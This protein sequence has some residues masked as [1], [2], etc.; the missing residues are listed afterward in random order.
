MELK[1]IKQRAAVLIL[2]H[3]MA[4]LLDG[5]SLDDSDR[6]AIGILSE[7]FLDLHYMG[8]GPK[9]ETKYWFKYLV[10]RELRPEGAEDFGKIVRNRV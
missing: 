10:S 2:L 7:R 3:S 9:N 6:E 5:E 8:K 1:E 4:H